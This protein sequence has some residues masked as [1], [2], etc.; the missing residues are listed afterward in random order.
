MQS[1]DQAHCRALLEGQTLG[2]VA[3]AN[4]TFPMVLPVN[5]VCSDN[6]IVFRTGPGLKLENVPMSAVAF[7]IDGITNSQA[8]SVVVLGH[9]RELTT[10]LGERYDALRRLDVPTVAPGVKNSWI[11]IEMQEVSGRTFPVSGSARSP[12]VTRR[13]LVEQPEALDR[14]CDV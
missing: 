9:A 3:F 7:E 13:A 2:R 10:A 5:Y 12:S 6:L 1:L 14:P 8:W 4:G 11:G